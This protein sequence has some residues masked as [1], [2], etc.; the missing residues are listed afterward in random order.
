MTVASEKAY[1]EL[2]WTGVETSFTPGF[3]ATDPTHVV[4]RFADVNRVITPLTRG[5]HFSSS[6]GVDGSVQIAPLA[7]PAPPGT[8]LI[9]RRTPATNDAAFADLEDFPAATHQLLA[10]KA[11]MRD[12]EIW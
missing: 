11:A 7:L 4:V 3:T 8:L 5:V 1:Q 12:A 9:S 2:G 10:D 6:L